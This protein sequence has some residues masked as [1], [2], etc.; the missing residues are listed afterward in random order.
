MAGSPEA[1]SGLFDSKVAIVVKI[2][3]LTAG[4]RE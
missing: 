4:L 3:V 1:I 2:A